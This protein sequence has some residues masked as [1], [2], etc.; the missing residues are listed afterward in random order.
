MW[1]QAEPVIKF[2]FKALHCESDFRDFR[3]NFLTF[4][5]SNIWKDLIFQL[6]VLVS[7]SEQA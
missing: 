6:T 7:S 1:V 3:K 5:F 2:F 4:P